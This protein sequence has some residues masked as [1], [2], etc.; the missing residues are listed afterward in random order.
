MKKLMSIIFAICVIL[1]AGCRSNISVEAPLET[2]SATQ[3]PA[4]QDIIQIQQVDVPEE[5][6]SATK[7]RSETAPPTHP[8]STEPTQPP[9]EA[10]PVP[11]ETEPQEQDPPPATEPPETE[12]M[13]SAVEVTPPT[14]LPESTD[15][16]GPKAT[17]A[18]AGAIAAKLVEHLNAYRIEQGSSQTVVLP[19]LTQYAEYRSRQL[20]SN[21]AHDTLDERAAATALE[22][23]SYIDPA[24]YGMTGDP[25][26]VANAREAIAKTDFGGS[27][28]AVAARLARLARNSSSHWSYVGN[29][30]YSYI[31]VGITY[32]DGVW[33]CDI[34]VADSNTDT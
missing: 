27:I 24:A 10:V 33:Y 20:A 31:G 8:V 26:Y 4:W 9:T 7:E 15:P 30:G 3:E 23:G 29:A 2:H 12:P 32:G 11:P 18:D 14:E 28:D 17:A 1:L 19:G 34:A 25:Y 21:F 5:T 6:T 22:Y 16:E 13:P